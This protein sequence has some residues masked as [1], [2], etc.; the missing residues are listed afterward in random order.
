[1]S[2]DFPA[3]ARAAL[4]VCPGLLLAWLPGGRLHYQITVPAL[5]K[6]L[7]Q[8]PRVWDHRRVRIEVLLDLLVGG[9]HGLSSGVFGEAG[10]G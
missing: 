9:E 2:T 4:Q 1:M 5:R 8:Y 6:F 7:I 10:H 3:I